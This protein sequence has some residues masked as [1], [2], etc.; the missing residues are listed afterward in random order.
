MALLL[1]K[2]KLVVGH[3]FTRSPHNMLLNEQISPNHHK[4]TVWYHEEANSQEYELCMQLV[5]N[6]Y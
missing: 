2:S 5:K 4:C 6:G 1:V 3:D